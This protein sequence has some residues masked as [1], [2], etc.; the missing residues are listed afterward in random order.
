MKFR[1][2]YT[3]LFRESHF[4][5]NIFF[6]QFLINNQYIVNR[7][8]FDGIF[9]NSIL[10]PDVTV[11]DGAT[12]FEIIFKNDRDIFVTISSTHNHFLKK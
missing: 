10:K 4:I 11:K 1:E 7:K 9:A 8:I 5:F 3:I 6:Y 12:L 2:I